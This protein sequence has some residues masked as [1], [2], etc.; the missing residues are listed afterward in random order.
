MQ[1]GGTIWMNGYSGTSVLK[2]VQKNNVIRCIF[3]SVLAQTNK[4]SRMQLDIQK[5]AGTNEIIKRSNQ[6]KDGNSKFFS[7]ISWYKR[8]NNGI[9]HSYERGK[10]CIYTLMFN[11]RFAK[12][13]DSW[14]KWHLKLIAEQCLKRMR[15]N[16]LE[17]LK[18]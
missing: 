16:A 9:V 6:Y 8:R 13:R 14:W 2:R 1:I 15:F 12:T 18:R 11:T 10:K 5:R 7:S 4:Y 17:L 3:Y